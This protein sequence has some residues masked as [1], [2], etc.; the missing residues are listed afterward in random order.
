MYSKGTESKAKDAQSVNKGEAPFF[1][2]YFNYDDLK[3]IFR[4]ETTIKDK[5][6]AKLYGITSTRLKDILSIPQETKIKV[7]RTM[8]S[9][10]LHGFNLNMN[11]KPKTDTITPQEHVNFNA[12]VLLLKNTN[13]TP[14]AII[15]AMVNSITNRHSK[16]RMRNKL[17]SMYSEHI[18]GTSFDATDT[19]K[20]VGA[21][22]SKFGLM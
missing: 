18:E 6:H 13:T 1:D 15:D 4:L 12:L 16:N 9:K 10:Y 17:Q 7:F 8:F 21:F 11:A 3:N 2:S 19:T 20:K 5:E 22:F 14:D